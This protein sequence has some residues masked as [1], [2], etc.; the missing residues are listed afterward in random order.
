MSENDLA[1][2][3]DP[4]LIGGLSRRSFLGAALLAGAG[5]S[6]LTGCTVAD[7]G[8][9]VDK[10]HKDGILQIGIAAAPSNIN[11][12]DSGSEVTRWISEPVVET[13]YAYDDE[14]NSVP[15]LADGEPVVS[16]DKLTWTIKLRQGITWH[17]GDP[18]TADDVVATFG[19]INALS[20]GSE[21][22]TYILGYV[23]TFSAL[24][25]HTMQI[26][27]A[28]PYGLLRSHLTNLPIVH[29]DFVNR[30]NAMMG[31]GP[32]KLDSFNP[33]Q[34]FTMS[35]YP[36]YHGTK[37][38]LKGIQYTVFQDGST[39]MVSLTQGKVDLITSV[40]YQNLKAAQADK[41]LRVTAVEA[42]LDILSYVHVAAEPFSDENFRRAIAVATDRAGVQGRVFGG[43]AEIG[44]G[45]IGPAEMGYDPSLQVYSAAPDLAKAG[46]YLAKAKTSKRSFTLTIGIEDTIRNV[47]T[48]LVAG[49]A[50]IGVTVTIEQ[51][52]GGAWSNSLVG[53][54]YDM[55]MDLFQSGF[56]SGP[57]NYLALAPADATNVLSCGYKNPE[58][59]ALTATVWQTSDM[60]ERRD[61]LARMNKIL[62]D[63]MV[64]FPPVYPKL[65]VAQRR[66]TSP[67]DT[68][69][70]RISRLSPQ[71]MS[72]IS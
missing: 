8:A 2:V 51:L 38:A 44:Q 13:L 25:K 36:G 67:I 20:S 55:I 52:Q 14:L 57:A 27:L 21:W 69:L 31:T 4:R 23:Q 41:A 72:F 1:P 9:R 53:R 26:G 42:P 10:R 11:P 28:K 3:A 58:V 50:K 56:T 61:A 65:V 60:A 30:K 16:A 18:F 15:L 22:V 40:P 59:V 54:K 17:N 66:E 63:D 70:L 6:V 68:K 47:A 39:R 45:P 62:A 12:L 7:S 32:F 19:H 33:G 71:K 35:A 64:V 43:Q 49:W 24:D 37:P 29:K 48:V 5:A 34:S 46:E